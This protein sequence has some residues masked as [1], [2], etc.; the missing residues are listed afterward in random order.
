VLWEA[1]LPSAAEGV[2]AVYEVGGREYLALC[3]AGNNGLT[4][5]RLTP[6]GP[7]PQGAYIV[8]ALPQK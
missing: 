2:P 5:P 4:P 3:A 7:A 8:Y 6:A 1:D